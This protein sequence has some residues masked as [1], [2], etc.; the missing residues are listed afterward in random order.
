MAFDLVF[1][2]ARIVDGTGMPAYRA[3]VAI[4]GARIARI[5]RIRDRARRTIDA[6]GAVTVCV[7]SMIRA[8]ECSDAFIPELVAARVRLDRPPGIAKSDAESGREAVIEGA[9]AE[10][11]HDSKDDAIKSRC[12]AVAKHAPPEVV[13]AVSDCMAESSCADYSKCYVAALEPTL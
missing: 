1:R 8:R 6:G 4:A 3:D 10:W 12:D 9:K 13:N 5:G 11:A 2:D 7:D